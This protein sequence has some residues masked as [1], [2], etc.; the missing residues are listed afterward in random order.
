MCGNMKHMWSVLVKEPLLC[1]TKR[2]MYLVILNGTGSL[3]LKKGHLACYSKGTS[4]LS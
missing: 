1:H 3:S 2:D 4:S